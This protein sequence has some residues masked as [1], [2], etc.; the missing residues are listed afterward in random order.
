MTLRLCNRVFKIRL[1]NYLCS[2]AAHLGSPDSSNFATEYT[3][4]HIQ[5]LL[6][7]LCSLFCVEPRGVTDLELLVPEVLGSEPRHC[8]VLPRHPTRKP[9]TPR[10]VKSNVY[11]FSCAVGRRYVETFRRQ[12]EGI[13]GDPGMV[14][15]SCTLTGPIVAD[16]DWSK[17]WRR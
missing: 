14:P 5:V 17:R 1:L 3:I 4:Y 12:A 15:G 10:P 13:H 8:E 9:D 2:S 7:S 16:S 6:M 11:H